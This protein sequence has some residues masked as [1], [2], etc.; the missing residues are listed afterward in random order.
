MRKSIFA[1]LILLFAAAQLSAQSTLLPRVRSVE[2]SRSEL[3]ELG[4]DATTNAA[5]YREIRNGDEKRVVLRNGIIDVKNLRAKDERKNPTVAPRL[6]VMSSENAS[7]AYFRHVEDFEAARSKDSTAAAISQSYSMANGLVS[8]HFQIE[9]KATKKQTPAAAIDVY[10]WYEPTE[11]F[12]G[13]LPDRYKEKIEEEKTNPKP[14]EPQFRQVNA[15]SAFALSIF[16]NPASGG[17]AT[18]RINSEAAQSVSITVSDINGN[19]AI[20]EQRS[21][22]IRE[23]DTEIT[24]SID[25]LAAGMYIVTVRPPDGAGISERLIVIH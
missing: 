24:I 18:L 11:E 2:L 8:V 23:G 6:A 21:E 20:P 12:I 25:G 14:D 22:Q 1:V 19:V 10:L 4:I 16:P 13:K 17:V 9:Q 7:S 3:A 15:P 5:E